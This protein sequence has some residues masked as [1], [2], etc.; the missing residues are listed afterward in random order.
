M[1]IQP[2]ELAAS[3]AVGGGALAVATIAFIAARIPLATTPEHG[4]RGLVRQRTRANSTFRAIEPLLRLAA[5]HV[6]R[7]RIPRQRA[8]IEASLTRG[9][10]YL[11]LTADEFIVTCIASGLVGLAAAGVFFRLQDGLML[12]AVCAALGP[13][14]PVLGLRSAI[15]ERAKQVDRG[16]PVA[17]DLAAMCMGAGLDFP[18]AVRQVV[19]NMP[20]KSTPIRQELERILQE[21]SL[22]RT[23]RQAFEGFAARVDTEAVNEFV[24]AVVQAEQ[25][26]TPLAEVLT[27]QAATLRMRRGIAAEEA[28]ARAGAMMMMPLVMMFLCVLLLL[29]GPLVL[30]I[31]NGGL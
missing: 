10:E 1:Q 17:I 21:L 24:N 9:G 13:L 8:R 28:A 31:V 14:L 29:M 15:G 26:G 4:S 12:P 16:L 30:Q 25:R 2:Y 6:G 22:G 19:A 3:L 11:G 18:G 20:R 23:R 5:A 27:I 7:L